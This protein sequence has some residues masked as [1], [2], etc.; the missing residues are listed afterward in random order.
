MA[1]SST[2]G[3]VALTVLLPI[4]LPAAVVGATAW[5][6]LAREEAVEFSQPSDEFKYGSIGNESSQGLP[7]WIW[8]VLPRVFGDLLPGNGGYASF[9]FVWE[10]HSGETPLCDPA[11]SANLGHDRCLQGNETPIG[12][13]KKTIGL[14]RISLNCAVCHTATYRLRPEDEPAKVLAAPAHQADIQAYLQ[15]L[16]NCAADARFNPDTLLTEIGY[17]VDL[18]AADEW[19]Y[20]HVLIPQTKEALLRQRGANSWMVE[21]ARWGPG[22]VD[23]FNLVKFGSLGMPLDQTVG[24]ADNAPLWQMAARQGQRLH[25]DGMNDSVHEAVLGSALSAG[26]S[27]KDIDFPRLE[28]IE[29]WLLELEPPAY[30]GP[31]DANLLP[32]GQQLFTSLCN[33]CHGT[34]G[35]HTGRVIP[36]NEVGTDAERQRVWTDDAAERYAAYAGEQSLKFEHFRGAAGPD[37][38]YGAMPLSGVW[39]SAPYLHNGSVPSLTDLLA[40]PDA[41]SPSSELEGIGKDLSVGSRTDRRSRS[42]EVLAIERLV[43]RARQGG[44]RPPVFFRGYDLLD[45]EHVG[46]VADVGTVPDETPPF[47]YDTRLVGNGN[48]GHAGERY[49]TTLSAED[50]RALVEYLKTL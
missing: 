12:F 14:P 21:R 47:V 24:N 45:T 10:R 11:S 5:Y 39:L 40:E 16:F 35:K 1:H 44:K 19:L 33:D 37:G 3:S 46:F 13:A 17:N 22:R 6:K 18:S 43:Q 48:A 15:F 26:A 30:P 41:A 4:L 34:G 7:Y 38:G 36:T 9:G 50:K 42:D 32:R 20:R 49:G 29:R 28:R 25:W 2:R 23:L 8:Y 27:G 31:V